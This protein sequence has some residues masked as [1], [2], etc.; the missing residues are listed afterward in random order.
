[1]R[2]ESKGNG[3]RRRAQN[4]GK[5]LDSNDKRQRNYTLDNASYVQVRVLVVVLTR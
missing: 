1:M 5:R 4:R 2:L 3:A